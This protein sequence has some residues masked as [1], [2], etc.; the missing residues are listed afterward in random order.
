MSIA[1]LVQVYDEV[2][3]LAIAGSSVAPGDFRLKKLIAPLE[4]AG[5]KAPVFAKVAQS[6][7]S[8][9]DSTDKTAAA[10]L[11]E[12]TTLVNAVLYTQGTTGVEGGIDPI[13]TTDLGLR[14]TTTSARA[15]KPL[16]E[17]L[18]TTGSGRVEIVKDAIERNLFRDLRLIKPAVGAIDDPYPEIAELIV[19]K[20]LP[21]YGK[22]I[23]PELRASFDMKSKSMGQ[24]RRLKLMHH[25]DPAGSRDLVEKSLADGSKEMKVAAIECLGATD[26]DVGY[27]I[28]Q[29]KAKSQDVRSAALRAMLSAPSKSADMVKSLLKALDGDDLRLIADAIGT[30]GIPSI[31]DAV[32]ERATAQ[33]GVI[34]K[35]KDPKALGPAIQRM[36]DLVR[37]TDGSKD[38][39][40][41]KLLLDCLEKSS[42]IAK[43]K[44]DPA[45]SD[46]NEVIAFRLSHG[47]DNM[48]R[49]LV[50][51][52]ADAQGR[53]FDAVLHAAHHTQTAAQFYDLFNSTLL[54]KSTTRGKNVERSLA[55]LRLLNGQET[56]LW[57]TRRYHAG[58]LVYVHDAD[59]SETSQKQPDFDLRWLDLAVERDQTELVCRLARPGHARA[60]QYL[61]DQL[62]KLKD[63]H[64]KTPV[65]RVLIR[66]GHPAALDAL[67]DLIKSVSRST[68]Y[69][70]STYMLRMLVADLPKSALPRIEAL[71][72]ELPEKFVDSIIDGIAAL[73]TKPDGE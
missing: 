73:R 6:I 20:V 49:Q 21:L 27:L 18:T 51:T 11:L 57:R 7:Q 66:L 67:I 53:C 48:K 13:P 42:V 2:R 70:Y 36:I 37:C 12:L 41:E 23:L 1:T 30:A 14:S 38:A 47:S 40:A 68:T 60:S 31:D 43:L 5:A 55:L 24:Q 56:Y 72:A 54:P 50:S 61:V 62:T 17:S 71:V 9:I 26:A 69:Y 35:E 32:I 63:V 59:Q 25:L 58:V 44:A 15:I 39:K 19:E 10:A 46:L 33:L 34:L 4:H 29:S 65:L 16:I 8:V 3:R 64:E 28:E 22:S 52:A 45:G